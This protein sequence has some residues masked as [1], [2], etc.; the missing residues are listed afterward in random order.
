MSRAVPSDL[1]PLADSKGAA[2]A[3]AGLRLLRWMDL[4]N[5]FFFGPV[6]REAILATA[7]SMFGRGAPARAVV[8]PHLAAY[9]ARA[10]QRAEGLR[11]LGYTVSNL[12]MR[13][14]GRLATGARTPSL[15]EQGLVLHRNLGLPFLASTSVKGLM[16][17]AA[18]SLEEAWPQEMAGDAKARQARAQK[19]YG[20][21][22]GAKAP[23]GS[24]IVFDALP[25]DVPVLEIDVANP[26]HVSYSHWSGKENPPEPGDGEAPMPSRFLCVG[27][28][29]ELEFWLAGRDPED[30]ALAMQHLQASLEWFGAGAKTASGYGF[31]E[32]PDAYAAE[33]AVESVRSIDSVREP[34]RT[35]ATPSVRADE[36]AASA[37]AQAKLA[38]QE[39]NQ[40]GSQIT[41]G[42]QATAT[43]TA[44]GIVVQAISV[45]YMSN[46]GQIVVSFKPPNQR[47]AVRAGEH[48]SAVVMSEEIKLRL[49]KK[50][51]LPNIYVEVVPVGN[52]W[53][54]KSVQG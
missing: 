46:S 29:T 52:G 1:A 41:E 45:Q 31:F 40:G 44:S 30:V 43:E 32:T 11:A 34:A 6:A 54:L 27:K 3:N 39:T 10:V 22:L 35:D 51:S 37:A 15:G 38:Q 9:H 48:V 36:V 5:D 47:D 21:D 13:C 53:K 19:L 28:G 2:Q 8:T 23:A 14:I 42:Y 33:E 26:H 12:R 25:C 4:G 24:L 50:K 20:G 17:R 7:C 18:L 16:K 49:K